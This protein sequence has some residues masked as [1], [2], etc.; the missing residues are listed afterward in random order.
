MFDQVAGNRL[1]SRRGV[2]IALTSPAPQSGKST[3]AKR[4]IERH[5]FKLLKF[6]A[7]LKDMIRTLL[8]HCD[9]PADMIERYVDGDLKEIIIPELGISS[10]HLQVTIGT[11]WG[12]DLVRQDLWVHIVRR[13][14]ERK[15]ER[16]IDIVI[17]DMRFQNELDM[18][19]ELYGHPVRVERIGVVYEGNHRSEGGLAHL[20]MSSIENS[21]TIENLQLV[22]DDLVR[23]LRAP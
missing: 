17:D 9:I 22:V 14:T 13:A 16:G 3:V 12:R 2:L 7:P 18:V 1:P 5:G 11:E 8:R 23:H 6:A 21:T 4:L 20:T 19:M 10:R 15:L